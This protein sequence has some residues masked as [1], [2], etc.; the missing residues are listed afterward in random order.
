MSIFTAVVF[1]MILNIFH[2]TFFSFCN[3]LLALIKI[4]IKQ[5][6]IKFMKIKLCF[7]TKKCPKLLNFKI[8]SFGVLLVYWAG[9]SLQRK[10]V[11]LDKYLLKVNQEMPKADHTPSNFLKAVFYKF[12]LAHSCILCPIYLCHS[13]QKISKVKKVSSE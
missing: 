12:Y 9:F 13:W 2:K 4:K 3:Y 8:C 1:S 6:F 5:N 7:L 10:D 11:P